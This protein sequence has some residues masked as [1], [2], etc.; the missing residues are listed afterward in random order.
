MF[1]TSCGAQIPDGSKF[2]TICGASLAGGTPEDQMAMYT[3]KADVQ[4]A[5]YE[6]AAGAAGKGTPRMRAPRGQMPNGKTPNIQMPAGGKGAGPFGLPQKVFI[7]IVAGVAALLVIIIAAVCYILFHTPTIN[8]NKYITVNYD[9]YNAIGSASYEIDQDALEDDYEKVFD[10]SARQ[11]KKAAAENETIADDVELLGS[12]TAYARMLDMTG[13]AYLLL[14]SFDIEISPAEELSNGDTV[15]LTWNAD[16]DDI[17]MVEA[18]FGCKVRYED[19]EYTVEG[20]EEI[21]TFDPFDGMEINYGGMSPDGYVDSIQPG[22]DDACSK[23]SYSVEPREDLANGDTITITVASSEY[24]YSD[25]WQKDFA[26]EYGKVPGQLTKEITVEGLSSY[27]SS[28]SEIPDDVM[29]QMQSQAE[30]AFNANVAA[31]WDADT[32]QLLG[33]D[34]IG[35]YFLSPKSGVSTRYHNQIYLIYKVKVQDSYSNGDQSYNESLTYYWYCRY[36]DLYITEDG[37]CS[38]NLVDYSTADSGS[39]RIGVD[40]GISSGWWSTYSWVY[41]GFEKLD[42]MYNQL[43]TTQIADHTAEN[44]VT[45]TAS[46]ADNTSDAEEASNDAD[47][48]EDDGQVLPDSSTKTLSEDDLEGLSNDEIQTA[49]NEIYARH[50]YTFRD[51]TILAAFEEYDWYEPTVAADDFSE[52][53]LSQTEKD[54]IALMREHLN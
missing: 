30:D 36:T 25:N 3:D 33:L 16:E 2:C 9:G 15:T 51:E 47:G 45:D 34:Y 22:N 12:Y 20:L 35:N 46:G 48:A 54:N 44:N 6:Q 42:L 23:L 53:S 11:I 29:E 31:N 24:Y 32:E 10:I 17:A 19:T 8:L 39:Q 14:D 28:A 27:A 4:R 21:E 5:G 52:D 38:V 50:G 13:K 26:E 43:V 7:G 18:L 49:I 1:C 37:E 41:Y 40:S